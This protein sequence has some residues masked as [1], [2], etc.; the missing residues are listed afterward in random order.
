MNISSSEESTESLS[1][2]P[3]KKKKNRKH[4]E[5]KKRRNQTPHTVVPQ[6]QTIYSLFPPPSQ[7]DSAVT[8]EIINQTA[9][10]LASTSGEQVNLG[11]ITLETATNEDN[12]E[13]DS[14]SSV[15]EISN[16][17]SSLVTKRD[18]FN[19]DTND[20]VETLPYL[21]LI[22]SGTQTTSE[23][24][25]PAPLR[26]LCS[27]KIDITKCANKVISLSLEAETG[28]N[29]PLSLRQIEAHQIQ[30]QDKN[31][32]FKACLDKLVKQYIE[33]AQIKDCWSISRSKSDLLTELFRQKTK[34]EGRRLT[35]KQVHLL[36]DTPEVRKKR[37]EQAQKEREAKILRA[38]RQRRVLEKKFAN[39]QLAEIKRRARLS[40]IPPELNYDQVVIQLS[41]LPKN[42][43]NIQPSS[44]SAEERLRKQ[45]EEEYQRAVLQSLEEPVRTST[46]EDPL[47]GPSRTSTL[48]DPLPGP[49]SRPDP[50]A[51][52]PPSPSSP[53]KRRY[54]NSGGI[55]PKRS[56]GGRGG[57]SN[58]GISGHQR[59]ITEEALPGSRPATPDSDDEVVQLE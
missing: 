1:L 36:Q 9:A 53:R 22:D 46:L 19:S 35:S 25:S 18:T 21:K 44:A 27:E 2:Q 49:S 56:R 41:N 10:P 34:K 5:R 31:T 15:I 12:I 24:R 59:R 42:N 48:E 13:S 55:Q 28:V 3:T 57:P 20:T 39:I 58:I 54:M 40:E 14:N 50:E 16:R 47:P 4:S 51:I 38:T 17:N 45:E 8:T 11:Q 43:A 6:K 7:S 30:I 26:E 52:I 37:E 33:T 23:I 29:Y 32:E